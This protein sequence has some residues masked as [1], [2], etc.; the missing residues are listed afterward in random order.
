MNRSINLQN[1]ILIKIELI[2]SNIPEMNG[3][4]IC[5]NK[6]NAC[7]TERKYIQNGVEEGEIIR[8]KIGDYIRVIV[9]A[10]YY[11]FM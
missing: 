4:V 3:E 6:C 1:I 2:M 5:Y 11:C 7:D 10:E 8:Y 9:H